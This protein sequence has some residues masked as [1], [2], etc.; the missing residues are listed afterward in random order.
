MH[1]ALGSDP[2]SKSKI[3]NGKD[4]RRSSSGDMIRS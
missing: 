3:K 2:K 1:K 4:H